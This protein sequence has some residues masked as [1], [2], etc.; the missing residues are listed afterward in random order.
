MCGCVSNGLQIPQ[1]GRQ[2]VLQ[3][4]EAEPLQRLLP[5]VIPP[6]IPAAPSVLR[7]R[8]MCCFR[9]HEVL[10]HC[11]ASNDLASWQLH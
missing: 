8:S 7:R 6:L 10:L 11:Y 5:K 9:W 3:A 1:C 2:A 4:K